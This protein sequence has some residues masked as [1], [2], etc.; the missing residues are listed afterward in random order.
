[1]VIKRTC[2]RQLRRLILRLLRRRR[3]PAPPVPSDR[4]ATTCF[5][6]LGEGERVALEGFVA[7]HRL[8][9][10]GPVGEPPNYDAPG[11][12]ASTVRAKLTHPS[13]VYDSW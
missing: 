7:R 8:S 5:G 1:M 3:C 10:Q 2:A 9:P 12:S 13:V 4:V 11:G 6:E